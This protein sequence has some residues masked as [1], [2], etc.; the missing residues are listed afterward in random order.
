MALRDFLLVVALAATAATP[1]LAQ[2]V[3]PSV[4]PVKLA[5][6]MIDMIGEF[7]INRSLWQQDEVGVDPGR[8]FT[9]LS[10]SGHLLIYVNK[11]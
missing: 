11:S 1:A 4:V 10:R 5:M 6:P 8:R 9:I 3:A 2:A 7:P